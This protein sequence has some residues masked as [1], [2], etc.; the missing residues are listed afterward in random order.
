MIYHQRVQSPKR[1][2][3]RSHQRSA[4]RR[5]AQL[6]LDGDASC[7]PPHSAARIFGS[8]PCLPV[9]EDHARARFAKQPHRL[10]AD[11]ARTAC[12]ESYFALK[13]KRHTRHQP[14]LMQSSSYCRA[15]HLY[16][17]CATQ[18]ILPGILASTSCRRCSSINYGLNSLRTPEKK[19][20]FQGRCGTFFGGKILVQIAL[21]MNV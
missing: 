9:A 21:S 20:A 15:M 5:R 18:S 4:F 17:L 1:S 2:H 6:L 3:R 13:H 12:N 10:R 14:T 7:W 19:I 8:V 11:S 16:K